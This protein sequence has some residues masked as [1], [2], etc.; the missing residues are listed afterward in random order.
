MY[1]LC[2]FEAVF[3]AHVVSLEK[4]GLECTTLHLL[5]LNCTVYKYTP[6]LNSNL[7]LKASRRGLVP[8]P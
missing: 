3:I 7:Y 1:N 4:E 2:L 5:G 8:Y 6:I